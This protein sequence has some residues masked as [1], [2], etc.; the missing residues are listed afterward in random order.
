MFWLIRLP[1]GTSKM[2][3][4]ESG[5][6]GR[7]SRCHSRSIAPFRQIVRRRHCRIVAPVFSALECLEIILANEMTHRLSCHLSKA[8]S[9]NAEHRGELTGA[10]DAT[11][12]VPFPAARGGP[13]NA[14]RTSSRHRNSQLTSSYSS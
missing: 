8:H 9:T 13:L 4:L 1:V 7:E 5:A 6:H 12:G 14:S 10:I 3:H 11:P 2:Q